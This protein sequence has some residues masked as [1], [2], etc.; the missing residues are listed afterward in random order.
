MRRLDAMEPYREALREIRR[1]VRQDPLMAAALNRSGL[2]SWRYLLASVD[3]PVEDEIGMVKVQGAAILFARVLDT[4]L[5]D[6][7]EGRSRTMARL[8]RELDNGER[9]LRF[10]KDVSR[11]TAPIRSLAHAVFDRAPR[12]RRRERAA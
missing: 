2:N 9:V 11:L 1:A 4:W 6:E 10:A 12:M 5:D 7:E 8:D 3:V